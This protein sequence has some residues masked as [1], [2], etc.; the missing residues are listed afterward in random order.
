MVG[1]GGSEGGVMS[2]SWKRSS[3]QHESPPQTECVWESLN[4]SWQTVCWRRPTLHQLCPCT[5]NPNKRIQPPF[6]H[7]V[8]YTYICILT[9]ILLN[10]SL[11]HAWISPSGWI[12]T[13]NR[14]IIIPQLNFIL[15]FKTP[16][17]VKG[18][19][20]SSTATL[21]CR[22]L[23]G[24]CINTNNL[25]NVWC[26]SSADT[27]ITCQR[28]DGADACFLIKSKALLWICGDT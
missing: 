16:D 25:E 27:R 20:T 21:R 19:L 15:L 13:G 17:Y 6:I 9:Y 1:E 4:L 2:G 12:K 23:F 8:S 11:L 28:D 18:A 5:L 7:S 10:S 3:R 24:D 26:F 22:R 14:K